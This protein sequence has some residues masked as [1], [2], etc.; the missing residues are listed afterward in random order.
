MNL[1]YFKYHPDSIAT[2]SVVASDN[3]CRCCRRATGFIYT[4]PVYAIAELDQAICPWCIA[5]GKAAEKFNA[6]FADSYPLSQKGIPRAIV[7]EVTLRTPGYESWQQEF[8]LSHCG[9]ACEFHGDASLNDVRNASQET[10]EEWMKEYNLGEGEWNEIT[11]GYI[12]K[13][14]N[15]I[16]KFRC[17]HCN[18]ILFGW[19][20]S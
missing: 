6:R 8:W 5:S 18:L 15:A 16:Y 19:D 10:K 3:I 2:G 1:P 7:E 12:P 4:G 17:R 11:T 13:G 9:D 20:C 14:H